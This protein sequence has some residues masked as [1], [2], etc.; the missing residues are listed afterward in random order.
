MPLKSLKTL[1]RPIRPAVLGRYLGVLAL[2]LAVMA[3]VPAAAALLFGDAGFALRSAAVAAFL[4]L[5][6]WP[7]SRLRAG[8]PIRQNEALAIAA[9]GFALGAAAMAW[10]FAGAGMPP[11]DALFESMS[12]ITTTGLSALSHID[13]QPRALLFARAWMQWYGG[14]AIIVL[15]LA[16]VLG[17]GTIALR[18]AISES[19]PEDLVAGTRGRARQL[20][21]VYGGLTAFGAAALWLAGAAPFDAVVHALSAIS[22]GGF[23]THDGSAA[24]LSGGRP[25]QAVLALLCLAG[26]ISFS[27]QYRAARGEPLLLLRDREVHALLLAMAATFALVTVAEALARQEGWTAV[28]ADAAFLSVSAQT[29][30]GFSTTDVAGLA[31]ASKLALIFSMLVGGDVGSTAGG[32][33]I[34]RLLLLLRLAQLLFARACTPPHAV[35][36]VGVGGRT[37][38]PAEIETAIGVVLLYLGTILASWL[39]FLLG[40]LDPLDSLFEIVSALGTVGLSAGISGPE[41]AP[42]LKLVLCLDMWMGRLEI[43]AV[44]VLAYPRSWMGPRGEAS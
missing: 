4:A 28:A 7:L 14:L 8:A 33:K 18:L 2:S 29:T 16:L 36:E 26:A 31:P 41:L 44:A 20:M 5:A 10:P 35:L 17:P 23:S 15:A 32:I 6:G 11:L 1:G 27:L 40:G 39:C 21:T 13:G 24:A 25:V 22:T 12:A 30:A 38:T 37:A 42:P 43:L 3:V 19:G 34:I 9:L